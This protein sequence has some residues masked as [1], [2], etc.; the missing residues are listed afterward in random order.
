MRLAYYP[1]CS[2]EST[3]QEYDLSFRSICSALDL[4]LEELEDWNC[5]GAT[6]AHNL[7]QKLAV[8]L[9]ARNIALA[10]NKSL[11]VAVP[12]AAC[13]SRLRK[14]D[15]LLRHRRETR[16]ELEDIV[17]F[18]YEGKIQV[19]SILEVLGDRVGFERIAA[20]VVKPL[21]GLKV[22]CYYGCL[23][24]RPRE[25]QGFDTVE[26]PQTLDRLVTAL[27]G[28]P[29][30]WSYKTECC[31]ASLSLTNNAVVERLVARLVG[32]AREA[33]ASAIVTACPLCQ[34]NLEM[35]QKKDGPKIPSLYIT[36]LLGLALG[37]QDARRWL[38]KHLN[39]PTPLLENIL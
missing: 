20:K 2:L 11:D 31:G 10:Q 33:G 34:T 8:S 4:E 16:R 21:T 3:A 30:N 12:C 17:D 32:A 19:L 28:K 6:S 36:E 29:L 9:P 26:H 15:W 24:V 23:L 18:K 37:L 27:G 22:V 7:N 13:F 25:V 14:A 39:N 1:G 5:C 35:R 38:A